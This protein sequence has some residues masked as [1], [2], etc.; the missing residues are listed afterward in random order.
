MRAGAAR[1]QAGKTQ[2]R[3]GK[4]RLPMRMTTS[5]AAPA[6]SWAIVAEDRLNAAFRSE[7]IG[8][9]PRTFLLLLCSHNL[10]TL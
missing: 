10:T 7:I 2:I 8:A 1:P 4:C 3:P 5:V 9:A 6:K